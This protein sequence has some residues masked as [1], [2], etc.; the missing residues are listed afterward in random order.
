MKPEVLTDRSSDYFL[1]QRNRLRKEVYERCRQLAYAS[2]VDRYRLMEKVFNA[3]LAGRFPFS[4]VDAPTDHAATPEDIREF[5]TA[6]DANAA[7]VTA[8]LGTLAAS[9]T[10]VDPALAFLHQMAAVRGV[11]ADFLDAGNKPA[12]FPAFTAVVDA[13][14]N[15]KPP[16]PGFDLDIAF[17]VNRAKEV[18]GN[19]IIDWALS[20]GDQTFRF[21]GATHTGQWQYGQPVLFSLRWAKDAPEH[22]TFAGEGKGIQISGRTVSYRF[23]GPWALLRPRRPMCWNF[24]ST[25]GPAMKNPKTP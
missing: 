4:A 18:G 23:D 10:D 8:T 24:P 12:A 22:P 20:I 14:G 17:R 7:D 13:Q 2:V 9:E 15:P 19:Q 11:F 16:V 25:P 6:Y 1:M 3:K 5:F 21:G